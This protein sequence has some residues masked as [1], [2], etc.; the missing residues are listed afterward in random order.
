M[1]FISNNKYLKFIY[2]KKLKNKL[3][4]SIK[5]VFTMG[6][7]DRYKTHVE[8]FL[9][10][11]GKWKVFYTEEQIAEML[12]I[13]YST[14]QNYKKLHKELNE[15]LLFGNKKKC[16]EVESAMFKRAIGYDYYEEKEV[17]DKD[18]QIVTLRHKKHSPADP[19]AAEFIEK[20]NNIHYHGEDGPTIKRQQEELELKKKKD[21]REE[22]DHW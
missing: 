10:D 7:A 4:M 2:N 19:R 3:N 9:E 20:I 12:G 15:V 5:E 22:E 8:P 17:L 16:N 21:K 14:L 13:A 1:L 18:G 6:R 11:I